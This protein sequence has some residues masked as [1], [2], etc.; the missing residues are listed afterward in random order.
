MGISNDTFAVVSPELLVYG[1]PNLRVID[2]SVM[3][4]IVSGNINAATIMVAEKGSDMIKYKW[5]RM[6]NNS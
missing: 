4:K 2:A 5:C 3:P 1:V 6:K